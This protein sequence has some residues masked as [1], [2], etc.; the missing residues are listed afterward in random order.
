ME[1]LLQPH[2]QESLFKKAFDYVKEKHGEV[3][4]QTCLAEM[5]NENLHEDH[6]LCICVAC[7]SL[8]EMGSEDFENIEKGLTE[9][10]KKS[11]M[12]QVGEHLQNKHEKQF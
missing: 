8:I 4:L 9:K 10:I 2:V 5:Y 11:I 12:M 3:N 1:E 6:I 7:W